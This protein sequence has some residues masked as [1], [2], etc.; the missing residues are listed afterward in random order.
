MAFLLWGSKAIRK[1]TSIPINEP[2][3]KV[4]RSAH[5]AV[6]GKSKERRF[7]NYHLFS[8]ANDFLTIHH[9][10]PVNWNLPAAD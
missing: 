6:W 1:A 3:H 8:E 2:P 10:E 9:P 5:P 4:I 7:K